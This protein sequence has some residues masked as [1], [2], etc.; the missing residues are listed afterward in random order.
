MAYYTMAEENNH[1]FLQLGWM[2]LLP[3]EFF[4][5]PWL[6]TKT[7]FP[8]QI[9]IRLKKIYRHR[10]QSDPKI[11]GNESPQPPYLKFVTSVF[12]LFP[13]LQMKI[14]QFKISTCPESVSGSF[15]PNG[16][17]SSLT[18]LQARKINYSI[19]RKCQIINWMRIS[20]SNQ[21]ISAHISTP[22]QR[23]RP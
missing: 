23:P 22:M 16:S 2:L 17:V 7:E 13:L 6:N 11:P 15:F 21:K 1:R 4:L 20:R 8:Q 3:K 9:I 19:Q 14:P 12:A 18:V 5:H 10:N